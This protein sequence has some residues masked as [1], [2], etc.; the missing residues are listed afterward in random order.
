VSGLRRFALLLWVLAAGAVQAAADE[1]VKKAIS[2]TDIA[3]L[4]GEGTVTLKHSDAGIQVTISDLWVKGGDFL[5]R[6]E[7]TGWRI[8]LLTPQQR[9]QRTGAS[10]SERI[11]VRRGMAAGDD[12]Q[13]GELI[14]TFGGRRDIKLD[15]C[16][17][18]LWMIISSSGNAGKIVAHTAEPS[19]QHDFVRLRQAKPKPKPKPKQKA[20]AKSEP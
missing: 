4:L 18:C 11:A 8:G 13:P 17:V 14:A 5:G 1:P 15:D 20:N 10:Y 7:I 6:I 2:T 12:Y 3:P 19:A 16:D 9:E